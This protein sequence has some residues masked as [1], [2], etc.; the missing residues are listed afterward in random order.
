[1]AFD[2]MKIT[3]IVVPHSI[4]IGKFV[5]CHVPSL[6]QYFLSALHCLIEKGKNSP[7]KKDQMFLF[8]MFDLFTTAPDTALKLLCSDTFKN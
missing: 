8:C 4:L 1:M 3:R 5:A 7:P 6:S 2:F